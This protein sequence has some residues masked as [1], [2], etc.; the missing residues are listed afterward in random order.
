MEVSRYFILPSRTSVVF[1]SETVEWLEDMVKKLRRFLF[2]FRK[3]INDI[4]EKFCV[5]R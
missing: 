5:H 3:I 4:V 2:L 1:F